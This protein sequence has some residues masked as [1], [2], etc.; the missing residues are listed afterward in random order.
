[1]LSKEV[2]GVEEGKEA[3]RTTPVQNLLMRRALAT[4]TIKGRTTSALAHPSRRASICACS[5]ALT[6]WGGVYSAMSQLSGMVLGDTLAI[7][8][9]ITAHHIGTVFENASG[10]RFPARVESTRTSLNI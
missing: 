8:R 4:T 9:L 10:I 1:V 5:C 6:T 3:Y 2:E 7:A